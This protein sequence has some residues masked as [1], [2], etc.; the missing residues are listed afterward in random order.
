MAVKRLMFFIL[1]FSYTSINHLSMAL[2]QDTRSES[3]YQTYQG[4]QFIDGVVNYNQYKHDAAR[5]SSLPDFNYSDISLKLVYEYGLLDMISVYGSLNL[6][7]EKIDDLLQ[8]NGLSSLNLGAKYRF[9]FQSSSF[10]SKMNLGLGVWDKLDCSA[11]GPTTPVKCNRVDQSINLSLLAGYMFQFEEAYL[12]FSIESGIFSTKGKTDLPG[13][14]EFKKSPSSIATFF[15]ERILGDSI[16][17]GSLQY[18]RSSFGGHEGDSLASGIFFNKDS[19]YAQF[20]RV[21]TYAR[22]PILPE[23]QLLG[24]IHYNYILKQDSSDFDGGYGLGAKA[25]VRYSF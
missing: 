16:W 15:Y 3:F 11:G 9:K 1:F 2:A 8:F 17:G 23:L 13:I 25:G 6:G 12:G 19:E 14:S 4:E 21:K 22:I 24:E 18:I 7:K 5:S 20:A 10:F